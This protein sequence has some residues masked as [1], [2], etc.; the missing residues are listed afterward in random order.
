MAVYIYSI[1]SKQHP[2]QLGGLEGVGDPPTQLRTV[3]GGA[4]CAVISDAPD[5]L[6]PKRRDLSAHHQVQ[7]RL[8]G[9]GAV[10]PLRFGFLAPDDEAVRLALEERAEEYTARLEALEDTVEYNLKVSQDEDTLLRQVLDSSQEARQ[11]NDEIRG[12]TAGPEAPVRLGELVAAEVQVRQQAL[13]HGVVEALRPYSR[14]RESSQLTG[15]DFLNV[16]FL[17]PHDQEEMFLTAELSVANQ[18]GEDVHFRLNGPLPPYSF[19]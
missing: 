19:V 3:I 13:A 15:E 16:S 7:D 17:V 1:T 5:G 10:L 9:D 12:G 18:L 2:L 11:L 14:D 6:R 4:L 8:M